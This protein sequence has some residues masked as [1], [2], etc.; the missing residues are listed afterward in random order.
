[1]Q[2]DIE[3]F[4]SLRMAHFPYAA[5]IT[6]LG[7][8]GTIIP[9]KPHGLP[10]EELLK[11][12]TFARYLCIISCTYI[13]IYTQILD[14]SNI[15]LDPHFGGFHQWGYLQIIHLH[16]TCHAAFLA[17]TLPGDMATLWEQGIGS[18]KSKSRPYHELLYIMLSMLSKKNMI[19]YGKWI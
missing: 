10:F 12:P 15:M 3:S 18:K 17:L 19:K 8:L 6:P 16:S 11:S 9:L 2:I 4:I 13:N 5:V 7:S 1:M 14:Y